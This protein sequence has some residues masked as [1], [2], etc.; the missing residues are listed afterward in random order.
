MYAA[1]AALFAGGQTLAKLSRYIWTC[2]RCVRI[3]SALFRHPPT[4]S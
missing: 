3:K 1:D 4:T 2:P